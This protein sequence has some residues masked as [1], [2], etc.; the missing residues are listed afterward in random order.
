MDNLSI[1]KDLWPGGYFEGNPLNPNS[2]SSYG[3][4]SWIFYEGRIISTLH[5]TY[6]RCIKPYIDSRKV[7]LEIGPGKGAWSKCMLDFKQLIVIDP[8]SAE[9]TGFYDYVG[10]HYNVHYEQIQDFSL[11]FLPYRFIDYVFSF[12]C[13]CHI[14]FEGISLYARNMFDKLKEDANCF[15]MIAD[16]DKF[17]KATGDDLIEGN[18]GGWHNTGLSRTC[19]LLTSIGYTVITQDVDTCSRDPIIHFRK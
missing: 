5:A 13:L 14:S 18:N 3:N 15:W 2:P 17:K 19:D 6:L 10:N 1:F 16:K 11:K 4:L 9:D 12:G 8:V 7:A